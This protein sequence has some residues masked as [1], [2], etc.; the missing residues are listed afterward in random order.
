M[1]LTTLQ[2]KD[3]NEVNRT[4]RVWDESGAGSGPYSFVQRSQLQDTSGNALD[5]S[6]SSIGPDA[7]T[8]VDSHGDVAVTLLAG[9]TSQSVIAAPGA[10]KQIW[11]HAGLLKNDSTGVATLTVVGKT[12]AIPLVADDG[13]QMNPSGNFEM[14]HWKIPTNTALL[15]TTTGTGLVRGY[16]SY[17]IV[18]VS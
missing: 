6:P 3:A 18:D 11:V 14:P 10:N 13:Y 1:T 15:I 8:A 5:P 4:M 12:G 16:L 2:I 17:S 9:T 7:I